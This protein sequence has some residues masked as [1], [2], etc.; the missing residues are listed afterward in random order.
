MRLFS[1]RPRTIRIA[2]F[3]KEYADRSHRPRAYINKCHNLARHLE[4]FNSTL[5][6]DSIDYQTAEGFIQYLS[7]QGLKQNTIRSLAA[8]L[9]TMLK[10]AVQ[11]GF[12]VN[13][14]IAELIPR[15]EET[16]AVY[17]SL[18][19]LDTLFWLELSPAQSKVRDLF[20][21]GCWTGQRY[22][23][24]SR[25]TRENVDGDFI[26]IKQQ[27]TG[28]PVVVPISTMLRIVLERND[29]CA[30]RCGS[31]QN[32]NMILK[33]ICRNAGLRESVLVEYKQNGL[34]ESHVLQKWELIGSHT[35]R[36]SFSTNLFLTGVAIYKIMLMT[37]HAT[38]S[39][40]LKYIRI[41]RSQN[42]HELAELPF[43]E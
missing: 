26:R 20:L 35:A 19:E 33:N 4:S 1:T 2:D 18:N 27:K 41:T 24:Y 7:D 21:I 28:V 14:A 5:K 6:S 30:P 29:Y 25:I 11:A 31:Q 15:E 3:I 34:V 12:P 22:S 42:A 16:V 37:G 8:G 17:L 9:T 36:R 43:F 23:D 13:F 40:F 32:F 38:E 10:R 39:A